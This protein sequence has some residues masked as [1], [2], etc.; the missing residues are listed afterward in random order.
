MLT[1]YDKMI[2]DHQLLTITMDSP[3]D[4]AGKVLEGKQV[5]FQDYMGEIQADK[6]KLVYELTEGGLKP[7][8]LFLEGHVRM[9]NAFSEKTDEAGKLKQYVLADAVEYVPA[10]QEANFKSNKGRRVLFYD[11]SNDLQIS[12]AALTIKRNQATKKDSIKGTGDVR[13][14]FI[15]NEFAL[16]RQRFSQALETKNEG[17]G[18]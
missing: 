6:V 1:C 13:F 4:P 5:F 14:S 7:A 9:V 2:V 16:L 18:L 15:E 12:A 10:T 11:K 17:T 3:K 8:K